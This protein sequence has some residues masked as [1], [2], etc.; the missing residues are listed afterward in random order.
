VSKYAKMIIILNTFDP[1]LVSSPC[2]WLKPLS[3][4]DCCRCGRITGHYLPCPHSLLKLMICCP[5]RTSL[6][7]DHI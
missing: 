7:K 4:E 6:K 1:G 5:P 3:R 2:I